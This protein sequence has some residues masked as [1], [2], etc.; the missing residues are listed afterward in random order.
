MPHDIAFK[1]GDQIRCTTGKTGNGI[2]AGRCSDESKNIIYTV[3][4]DFGNTTHLNEIEMLNSYE[5]INQSPTLEEFYGEDSGD[6]VKRWLNDRLALVLE[7]TTG[8]KELLKCPKTSTQQFITEPTEGDVDREYLKDL[9]RFSLVKK[10]G[11]AM[12]FTVDWSNNLGNWTR[13]EPYTKTDKRFNPLDNNDDAFE[14]MLA[15]EISLT[16]RDNVATAY[17]SGN[18]FSSDADDKGAAVRE[19]ITLCAAHFGE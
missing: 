2:I 11:K 13:G 14:V 10:A 1:V 8:Y 18:Y 19:A 17:K 7:Q 3:F 4:T 5:L 16:F 12:G 15:L 9:E 6:N